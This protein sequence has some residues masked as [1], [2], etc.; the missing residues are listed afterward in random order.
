MKIIT[1]GLFL[2]SIM[3]ASIAQAQDS[4]RWGRHVQ[5][6]EEVILAHEARFQAD[7]FRSCGHIDPDVLDFNEGHS[8]G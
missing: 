4:Q 8:H 6:P 5:K 1:G 7:S 3:I 2:V